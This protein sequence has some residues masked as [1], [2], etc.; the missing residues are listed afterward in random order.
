M[1]EHFSTVW[2]DRENG[3]LAIMGKPKETPEQQRTQAIYFSKQKLWDQTRIR[4][5]LSLHPNYLTAIASQ[6]APPL[7]EFN[8]KTQRTQHP[9]EPSHKTHR[10]GAAQPP[11]STQLESWASTNVPGTQQGAP[12]T[13]RI[14][15]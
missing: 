10:A 8:Q 15:G 14:A 3:V 12:K 2:L 13:P 11:C 7:G 5:W 4:D 6:T 9:R 1:P